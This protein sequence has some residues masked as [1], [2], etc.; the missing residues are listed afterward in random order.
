L[1]NKGVWDVW[2]ANV[3]FEDLPE[4]K[5][6]P[7]LIVKHDDDITVY[8]LKMTSH[9]PRTGEYALIKWQNAG[10]KK[11]TTVRVE[12]LL[13]LDATFFIRKLGR[14]DPVDIIGVE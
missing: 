14:L 6:R 3:P 7:V 9:I 8:C 4:R 12:K 11:G 5:V 2:L 1:P 13:Q 10:L